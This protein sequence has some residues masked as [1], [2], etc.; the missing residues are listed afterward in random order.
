MKIMRLITKV[1]IIIVNK[2]KMIIYQNQVNIKIT[3]FYNQLI[4]E[5]QLLIQI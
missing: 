5:H 3:H 2:I 1:I 4:T